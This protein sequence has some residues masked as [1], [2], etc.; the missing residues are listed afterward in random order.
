MPVNKPI[1]YSKGQYI[2]AVINALGLAATPARLSFFEAWAAKENTAAQFNPFATTYNQE[3]LRQDKYIGGYYF[4]S[5]NGNPVKNYS[6]FDN[7]VQAFIKTIKLPYYR[8]IMAG[9][10][11][12]KPFEIWYSGQVQRELNIYGGGKYILPYKAAQANNLILYAGAA[13]AVFLLSASRRE[14]SR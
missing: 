8:S 10:V 2:R 3:P 4:N 11:S 13:M 6:T 7:G 5:N 12:G 9:I 14:A 1:P